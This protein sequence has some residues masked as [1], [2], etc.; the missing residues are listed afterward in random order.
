M[1]QVPSP[2]TRRRFSQAASLGAA[3]GTVSAFL[4]Q[5]VWDQTD[6]GAAFSKAMVG[7]GGVAALSASV[8]G[9]VV[10]KWRQTLEPEFVRSD[11]V[12]EV[13]SNDGVRSFIYS[14]FGGSVA[15]LKMPR[16]KLV[17][18]IGFLQV[19]LQLVGASGDVA[20]RLTTSHRYVNVVWKRLS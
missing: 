16:V 4:G 2:I 11:P 14:A 10:K 5:Y 19:A 1:V 12:D 7:V 9:V 20:L 6:R 8:G 17:T 3:F 18:I 13:H 15:L